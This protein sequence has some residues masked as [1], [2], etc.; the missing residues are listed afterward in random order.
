MHFLNSKSSI[1]TSRLFG[2]AALSTILL[3]SGIIVF[4]GVALGALS[5]SFLNASG[6]FQNSN[7]ARVVAEGG[8]EDALLQLA[9]NKSFSNTGGYC[10]PLGCGADSALVTVTQ[11]TPSIDRITVLSTATVLLYRVRTQAI[12]AIDRESGA[13]SL[14]SRTTL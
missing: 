8:I 1:L 12:L 9:R 11:D 6:G 14:V 10:V 7:R 2:Q 5:L 3:L 4:A 13:F